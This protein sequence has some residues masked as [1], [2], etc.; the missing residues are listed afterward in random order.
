MAAAPVAAVLLA[1]GAS[2]RMGAHKALIP[3]MGTKL[4]EY[5]LAQLAA[6]DAVREIV[7]VTGSRA[8]DLRPFVAS[9]AKAR[10]AHNADWASGKASSVRCGAAAVAPDA[11]AVVLLAVDQPRP[12]RL[13][14]TLIE[15]HDGAA[16]R[17]TVPVF[18]GRRG[19]PI[20]FDAALLP[21]LLAVDDA[22]QGVRAVVERH[23]ADVREIACDDP[24]VRLDLNT[25]EDVERGIAMLRGGETEAAWRT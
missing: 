23:A 8:D 18:E 25:P 12:A 21:E 6:V 16:N 10:E 13:L 17:I 1:A 22:T 9:C 7:V 11:A 14:R 2:E 20:I 5:Q 19:H 3:W 4:L 24:I 15:S